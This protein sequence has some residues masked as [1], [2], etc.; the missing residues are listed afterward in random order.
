MADPVTMGDVMKLL[1]SQTQQQ[2]QQ[3]DPLDFSAKYNTPIPPEKQA[4]FNKWVAAKT[5]Q[6]GRN[7]LGDKYDY[8]V[9]G[10]FLATNGATDAR[11][12]GTDQFKKPNHPT[13]SNESQYHGLDGYVGGQ[14]TPQG[15]LPSQTNLQFRTLPQ[16]QQYFQKVEPETRLLPATPVPQPSGQNGILTIGDL[17]RY[18]MGQP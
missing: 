11:G 13:F 14:W 1:G 12:H 4:A 17:M 15:Y 10:Y 8:D 9:N 18:G 3:V 16:L 2:P 5:Q 6:T 7:P